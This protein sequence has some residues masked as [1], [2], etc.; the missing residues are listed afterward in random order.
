MF[1]SERNHLIPK[2]ILQTK[3]FDQKSKEQFAE[4]L[5]TFI[6]EDQKINELLKTLKYLV[7]TYRGIFR[8][9]EFDRLHLFDDYNGLELI[10]YKETNLLNFFGSHPKV[11]WNHI[12]DFCEFLLQRK[13]LD[14][15]VMIHI[16]TQ[17][18]WGFTV[19]TEG[20]IIQTI[21][22]IE[23]DSIN[24]T[25][26]M[27]DKWGK[28]KT[29]F[30]NAVA[31]FSARPNPNYKDA[32]LSASNALDNLARV[33]SNNTIHMFSKWMAEK[34]LPYMF[35]APIKNHADKIY[36]V[37]ADFAH[38]KYEPDHAF[39]QWYLVNCSSIINWIIQQDH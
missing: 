1:F 6:T 4:Y 17:I 33:L 13:L 32:C 36:A 2:P 20:H 11:L 35:P 18:G 23:L 38:G 21:E 5:M 29:D 24:E 31:S 8:R 28:V 16:F 27:P 9:D 26:S 12:I 37:R 10:Y 30:S 25:L 15:S 14:H 39:A 19:T 7:V 22:P 3:D 34:N